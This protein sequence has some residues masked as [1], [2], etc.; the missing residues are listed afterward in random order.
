M[1]Q[2]EMADGSADI[3]PQLYA[4]VGGILYLIIIAAGASGEL[5]VRGS[6]VVPGNA[7]VTATNILASRYLWRAGVAGDL[8]M[9]VVRRAQD[10]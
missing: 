6:L 9:H 1:R 3:S 4:R 7:A 10:A 8:L 2:T 5:F